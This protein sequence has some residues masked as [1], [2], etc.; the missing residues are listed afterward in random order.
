MR[1][2]IKS[3]RGTYDLLPKD[4][5]I[6]L[7]ISQII[8]DIVSIYGFK[9][10]D[11]PIFEFTE[12]FNVV[13]TNCDIIHKETYTFFDRG[14]D[15]I[16]LRPEG[17][18]AIARAVI[19]NG[20]TQQ[21]P[22]KLYYQ[23]PM[24]RYDRPQKGRHRQFLQSGVEFFGEKISLVDAEIIA[25]AD[26]VLQFLGLRD[27]VKLYIN[28]IADINSR[29]KYS[30]KL[31]EYFNRYLIDLSKDSQERVNINPLRIL[32]SKSK[33]DIIISQEA[34][35][36]DEFLTKESKHFFSQV[37]TILEYL[38]INYIYN[39]KLMRGLDYYSY[40]TFEFITDILGSQGTVLAGGRYDMLHRFSS[41]EAFGIGWAAG[42][43]RL[44]LLWK[45]YLE[46]RTRPVF[47]IPIGIKS[48][49]YCILLIQK[50]RKSGIYSEIIY[51][52]N[53][54]KRLTKSTFFNAKWVIILGEKEL[55]SGSATVKFLDKGYQESVSLIN[56]LNY[57][58]RCVL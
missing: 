42:L 41:L 37:C 1:N 15:S 33:K 24:F 23:G 46:T 22:I 43:D 40:T 9:F 18:A 4:Y 28:N 34:P 58:M 13:G 21:L 49:K 32:D 45:G 5:Q 39:S 16:T 57:F 8:K 11:T 48:E 36:I 56:L 55:A 27:K 29:N 44:K 2:V 54:K 26:H 3:V 7:S 51:V 12:V 25:M 31:S 30:L 10:I 17:T 20:L 52:G 19:S 38:N 35:L 6:I 14:G 53:L 47:F 50:F